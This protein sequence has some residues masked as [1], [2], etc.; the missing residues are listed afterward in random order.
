[1][2][3]VA[4]TST[5]QTSHSMRWKSTQI[6]PEALA[7][8]QQVLQII[9]PT[10]SSSREAC[11]SLSYIYLATTLRQPLPESLPRQRADQV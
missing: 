5:C 10:S 2:Q 11:A 8:D 3:V 1:M 9:P 6:V 7:I 4:C